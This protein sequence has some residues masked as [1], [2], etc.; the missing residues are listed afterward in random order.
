[1]NISTKKTYIFIDLDGT[2]IDSAPGIT[3]SLMFALSKYGIEVSDRKKLSV[4][5]GPPMWESFQKYYGFSEEQAFEAARYYRSYFQEEGIF[6]NSVYEGII[7]LLTKLKEAGKTLIVATSKPIPFANRILE[8][9]KIDKFF[10]F[11]AGSELD[12]RRTNKAE[13]IAYALEECNITDKSKV[14]MIGD[15]E[16]DIFGAREN[17]ISV[18]GVLYGYG[19]IDE[20]Q[21]AKADYIVKTTKEIEHLLC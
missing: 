2:L 3:K 20:L 8:H 11:V 13:V 18:I 4:F 5:I 14:I 9:A 15:R 19:S 21:Q 10:S 1:M 6:D 12:G 16:H 7:D 17:G